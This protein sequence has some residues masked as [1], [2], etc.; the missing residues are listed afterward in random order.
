MLFQQNYSINTSSYI[1]KEHIKISKLHWIYYDYLKNEQDNHVFTKCAVIS[2]TESAR[3]TNENG[4]NFIAGGQRNKVK[5][6]F[7]FSQKCSFCER[8]IGQFNIIKV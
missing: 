4:I 2:A 5:F 6:M 7:F 1:Y 3:T 8:T